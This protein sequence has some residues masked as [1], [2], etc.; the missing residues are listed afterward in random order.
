MAAKYG[1]GV[2]MCLKLRILVSLLL[3]LLLLVSQSAKLNPRR[4]LLHHNYRTK[5][6]HPCTFHF[7]CLRSL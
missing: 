7:E 3:L 4:P 2:C 5:I 1:G 6:I